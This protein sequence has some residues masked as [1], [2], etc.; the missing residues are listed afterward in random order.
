VGMRYF[1]GLDLGMSG[2]FTS[3]A[4]LQ[5]LRLSPQDPPE[6][7]RPAY[8]LRHLQ[9]FPLGTSYPNVVAKI[10]SLLGIP[11]LSGADLIVDQTAVGRPA[12]ALLE[13]GLR[14]KVNC[15]LW[16]V[17]MVSGPATSL[18]TTSIHIPKTELVGTL[19]VLLQGRRLWIARDLPE[20][21][22]LV[23]ELE[24]F[25]LKLVL[26]REDT[27]ELWREGPQDDLVFAAALAAWVGEQTLPK[28]E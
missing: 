3:L 9:R 27:M 2:Q 4:L 21:D 23:R 15:C 1:V 7:Y 14:N 25:K 12:V 8:Q 6:L 22:L 26:P 18:G 24:N 16:K 11:P 5:R 28:L 19:Q 13:D 10:V 20:A 17:T